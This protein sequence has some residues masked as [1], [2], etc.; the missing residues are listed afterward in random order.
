MPGAEIR[1][2]QSDKVAQ[3]GKADGSGN[4]VLDVA[5]GE[6]RLEV[7]APDFNPYRELVRVSPNMGAL[8]VSMTLATVST[9]VDV[10]E[11]DEVSVDPESS[12][13]STTISGDAVQDLPE[14]E[15]E[16]LAYL[17]QMAGTTGGPGGAST[18]IIDG[19]TG[20]R[21]P[22]RDQIQEI[23]I[24]N[25]PF[26][27]EGGGQG[28]RIQIIT[29]AG[30]GNW[31]GNLGFTF[32][33]ESLNAK[34]P[35]DLNRPARQQRNLN[36]SVSGPIIPKILSLTLNGR[37]NESESEGNSIRAVTPDG[38]VNRGIVSPNVTRSLN[39]R[40]QVYLTRTNT[41]NFNWN[42]SKTKRE[43]QGIGGFNLPERA[44]N[45]RNR[46][47]D[48]QISERA[49][50]ST[51][52]INEV[53]FQVRR[54]NSSQTPVTESVAIN[55][56]DAFYGGGGQNR[57][58]DR[59]TN[60]QVG[61][62][63]RWTLSKK[64]NLQLGT[65][66]DQNQSHSVSEN[67]FIG[68]FT[69]SSLNDYLEGRPATYTRNSGDPVLDVSQREFSTFVQADW[70]ATPK[71]NVGLGLRYQAQ[72][73]LSDY[74]NLAP[75]LSVAYQIRPTTVIRGGS[76][77][78]YGGF[79]MNNVEQLLRNDG[80][81]RQFQTVI[82]NPSYPDPLAGGT[83]S[84]KELASSVR[85]KAADLSSP[86][87][88]NSSITMEQRLPRGF[89]FV[90]SFDTNRGIHQIRTR[91]INAPFPG[92][93]LPDELLSRLNSRTTF[94]RD[95]ARA[96]VDLLRPF[97]PLV[98]N[99]NQYESVGTSFSKNINLRIFAQNVTLGRI[100]LGGQIQ[101]T[102][103]WSKD[104]SGNP[105]NSYDWAS[106]WARS[107]Q[108][109]R[110]RIQSQFNVRLPRDLNFNFNI[111]ANSSRPFNIT[112]GRD[113][114]GDTSTND[115]PIGVLRNSGIGPSTYNVDMS[116]NK[117]FRMRG[118]AE[119]PNNQIR[120][121]FPAPQRGGG[122]GGG[123]NAGGG[124]QRGGGGN[125]GGQRNANGG[126]QRNGGFGNPA[127]PTMTLNI[128]VSNLLNNT[129]LT[130]YSGVQTS[131]FFGKAT[132]ASRGRQ[133]TLGLNMRF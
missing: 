99:I 119:T 39:T 38:F 100:G 53:R 41:L 98:G 52:M 17:Q 62:T 23:I 6:Y 130:N 10:T 8:S 2:F 57:S 44:S 102:L 91:N 29:R 67:N 81:T 78:S 18:L 131:P 27:A 126:N 108:D 48:L 120:N 80:K 87:N 20:G 90:G 21:L 19:F 28:A 94:V 83:V 33:D 117:T 92:T 64:W 127:G 106:E 58:Q 5:P 13:S 25:N 66:L 72:S 128:Q 107:S 84:T 132:N 101:Y 88:V 116:F 76:R 82:S 133:L 50:F 95:A 59:N 125:Q 86:Y 24:N 51:T 40:G 118:P 1:L 55:V 111:R 54:D 43:N 30:T 63:L 4:F 97:Y 70:R 89:R 32:Q 71:M 79:S 121:S 22:P 93:R 85:T 114:N 105:V 37:S 42:Y 46:N 69:F 75:T 129:Q 12:L 65:E 56:L 68:T 36:T 35:F 77:I 60:F 103:G 3:E 109:Q 113:E 31:T 11:A 61:D 45:S 110:H 49:V 112:T 115:R 15:E 96:E 73:N 124:G 123:G 7:I 74:D 34:N 104:D 16:L 26:S 47:W 14:N 122:G 9:V